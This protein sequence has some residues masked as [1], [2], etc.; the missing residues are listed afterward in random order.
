MRHTSAIT[1]RAATAGDAPALAGFARHAG[2]GLMEFYYDGL[3]P[4]RT[5]LES[6][7]D[8]RIN[9]PDGFNHWSRWCVATGQAGEVLGGLNA[10]PHHVFDQAPSDPLLEGWRMDLTG[11]LWD[12]ELSLARGTFY[13]NMIAVDPQARGRGIGTILMAECLRLATQAGYGCVTLSTFEAD[14]G[15]MAFY[16][17][18]GFEIL[19][20]TP[21]PDHPALELGGHWALLGR[22]DRPAATQI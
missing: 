12:M 22:G 8:R 9:W 17:R 6:I 3:V 4:G 20:R 7:V 2:H 1:L 21:I 15:L 18:H 13:L 5:V 19:G 16:G 14:A 10:F 11:G